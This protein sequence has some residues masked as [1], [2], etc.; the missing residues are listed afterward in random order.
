MST[1]TN[2][3]VHLLFDGTRGHSRKEILDYRRQLLHVTSVWLNVSALPR[4]SR[5]CLHMYSYKNLK[6]TFSARYEK[7]LRCFCRSMVALKLNWHQYYYATK[8]LRWYALHS[9]VASFRSRISHLYFK[10]LA[11]KA[12]LPDPS[13]NKRHFAKTTKTFSEASAA[14]TTR[15]YSW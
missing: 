13:F 5:S 1:S 8:L 12:I 10:H 4:G 2:T 11:L 6:K 15:V 9:T 7:Y 3:C 14:G